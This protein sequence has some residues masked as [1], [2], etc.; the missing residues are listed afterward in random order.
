MIEGD[1][2]LFSK[3][4]AECWTTYIYHGKEFE[5]AFITDVEDKGIKHRS[6]SKIFTETLF[7]ALRSQVDDDTRRTLLAPIYPQKLM[8]YILDQSR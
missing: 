8:Q 4:I 5:T 6:L 2:E 7:P 3:A 1:A